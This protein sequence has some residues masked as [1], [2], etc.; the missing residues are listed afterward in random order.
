MRVLANGMTLDEFHS[1]VDSLPTPST[2]VRLDEWTKYR[3]ILKKLSDQAADE[4]R[5]AVW[6]VNGKWQ[7][8]GLG[9]IPRDEIVDYAYALV[10]KYSEGASAAAC[11]YYDELAAISKANVPPAVP[12]KSADI[13]TVAKAVNFTDDTDQVAN[14]LGRLVKRAGQDTTL[15]NAIR[16]GAQVAWIPNGDTCAFCLALA[17]RG[18]EYAGKVALKKGH[19]EHIHSNCDCAYGVR[20]TERTKYEGYE[21][22]DYKRLYD[23]QPGTPE[24]KI[25]AMRREAYQEN[26]EKINEQKRSAYAKRKEREASKAEE[27]NVDNLD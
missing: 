17:S 2:T 9:K 8:V 11:V 23:S 6:N 7:G 16:D 3:D 13:K 25:N 21:P 22:K 4:F 19:A 18:W 10:T 5:D 27:I 12:A 26:K 15:R 14:A 20:F 1:F 24:E